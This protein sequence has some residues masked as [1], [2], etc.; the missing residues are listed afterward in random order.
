M[1]DKYSDC[2]G[3]GTSFSI[4]IGDAVIYGMLATR[5]AQLMG[6]DSENIFGVGLIGAGLGINAANVVIIEAYQSRS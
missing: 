3:L 2:P 4:I 1:I 5:I 6:I